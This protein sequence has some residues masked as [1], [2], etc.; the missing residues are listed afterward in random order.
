MG[1][2][3]TAACLMI[4]LGSVS[5]N[6]RTITATAAAYR[7]AALKCRKRAAVCQHKLENAMTIIQI[8]AGDLE[9]AEKALLEK[10]APQQID[11]TPKWVPP[12]LVAVGVVSGL[13]GYILG[14]NL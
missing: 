10:E 3:K 13:I 2:L 4:I 6:G 14:A 9:L 1:V 12:T 7:K 11:K 8:Q 5:A